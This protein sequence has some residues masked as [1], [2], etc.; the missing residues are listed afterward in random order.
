MVAPKLRFKE[1]DGDWTK[2]DLSTVSKVFDGTHQTPNY[3]ES[4]IK[5]V[6]V[7]NIH[8]PYESDKFITEEAFKKDFK[9][10]PQPNDI[11][12]TRITAGEIGATAI[13]DDSEPLAYY[14]SLALIRPKAEV[15]TLYLNQY[16]GTPF[17]KS[18]LHKRIIHVAFPKKINLG[19]INECLVALPN[20]AVEQTKIASFLSAVD[21]KISQL[22]EKHQLLSQYK[23]GMMQ[24]LFSQQLRFKADDGSEFGE[25]EEVKFSG[26]FKFHQ[27]NSYS[28]ALLAEY[29]EIMNIHYG[30]IHTKFSMLFDV[31]KESV[32]FLNDEVDTSKIAK[33]QFLK[34]GDLVIADASEDYKDIG[35]SIEVISLNN[36][37]VVA[38]LHT[39]IARP[40]KPFALGFCGYMMQ[41]FPVREQIKKLAT[42]ISVL[43][44][45]KT[46]LGKVE[47][48]VP[49]LEEQTKI[50]NFLSAIDQKIEVVAQQ[51]EQ[52]KTWKKG[53]LQQMF[54]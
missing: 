34:V 35:K 9:N 27:T 46:N 22:T 19:D 11:L 8:A 13:V 30:D 24:K 29:G 41:T 15:N 43:G 20:Q 39:Y 37:K 3:V 2:I 54:V 5:F 36:Q 21:E 47:L 51:I 18:E 48:K 28:R 12:M 38:G 23:Q 53:L 4:G 10:Q 17:F 49:S 1:F 16:I 52:A 45:S 50:A 40:V 25:W 33:E 42:G 6:S 14:V 44:I 7:E 32:P 31:N 26:I